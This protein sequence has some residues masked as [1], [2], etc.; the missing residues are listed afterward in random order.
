VQLAEKLS[1][2]KEN[3][4]KLVLESDG[5]EI[6]DIEVMSYLGKDAAYLLLCGNEKWTSATAISEYAKL[7]FY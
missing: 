6:D 7:I 2:S 5:T 4:L 3:G 1:L